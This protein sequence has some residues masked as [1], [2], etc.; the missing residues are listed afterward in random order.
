[1]KHE[2]AAAKAQGQTCRLA[3]VVP[4]VSGERPEIER[5]F[6]QI[7]APAA[8]AIGASDQPLPYEFSLGVSLADVPMARSA[9]LLLRWMNEALVQAQVSW[10]LLSGF[11]CEQQE[12]LLAIA[13]FDVN[14][15]RRAMRQPEQDLDSF[16]RSAHPPEKLRHRLQAAR[17]LLHQNS[18]MTFAQWVHV[19]DQMLEAVHWPGAHVLESED[20][21]VQARWS[22]LLDSVAALAFD[23]RL[24]DYAGFLEVLEQQAKQTIFAPESRDAPVQILGPLEA[25]GLTFDALWFLGAA[26]TSWP[27]VGRPHPFLTRSLQRTHNM[28]HADSTADWKLAQQV[29]T[30]LERS[31]A[32]CIFSF[33]LQ[34][35]EGA[36]RPSTLVSTG[37]TRLASKALRLSIGAH[38]AVA[39][40]DDFPALQMDD[41]AAAILP[42]PREQDAGGAE[43]LRRQAACPFQSFAT[44]RLGAR[45]MDA[46]D[47]G[48]EPRERGS[49]VHKIL[50]SLWTELK[51]RDALVAA[52]REAR[53]HAIVE[54]HVRAALEKFRERT[55]QHSWSQA[56]LDAEEERIVSLIEEWLAYEARR[57]DFI[58]EA[59]EEKLAASVGDLKL[60]VRVDRID[61]VDGGRVIIDYKT[62]MLTGVSWDG[63]RPDEPQLPLYAGFGQIDHLKGVL[64]GRVRE[65]KVKFIGRVENARLVMPNDSKLT[66]PAY[67]AAMLQSWQN[68]LRDLGQQFLN[69]EAQVDPKQYPKTCEFCD[70]PGLCRI[71]ESD[72]VNT[73][74]EDESDD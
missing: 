24:T 25:A 11:L 7:L 68:V 67:S 26:D 9:L 42:W 64:L 72:P 58:V 47:W 36:C 65:D 1:V 17:R 55:Q 43:I 69:G 57:A 46:T 74:D 5:A 60:Q 18:S 33:P 3:V 50:E 52:Q 48:L 45:P 59:G 66:R 38:E 31:A 27:S 4:G 8:V 30:R 37:K 62:G 2:L 28:P 71:A 61:A 51:T 34:N 53:L 40:E 16:L 49:V 12:E 6:R 63:P 44:R 21:Q 14:V 29:T 70:L 32:K 73:G 35:A 15:R 19:A 10:L 23:G 20:F 56:Y 54:Q 22:Q 39:P 13:E 41:E